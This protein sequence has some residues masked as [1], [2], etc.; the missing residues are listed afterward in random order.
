MCDWFLFNSRRAGEGEGPNGG[1]EGESS[2]S[3]QSLVYVTWTKASSRWCMLHG[4]KP[5]VVGVCYMDAAGTVWANDLG[6]CV[7][8][9]AG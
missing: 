7:C 8:R 1:S 5:A 4:R 3:Q 6:V 9:G 2:K